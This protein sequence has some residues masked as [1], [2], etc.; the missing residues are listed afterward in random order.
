MIRVNRESLWQV[1][2]KYNMDG[3]L[4]NGIKSIYVNLLACVRV[5]WSESECFRV[6]S[7]MRQGCIISLWLFNVYINE[8]MKE[9]KM[10]M[11]KMG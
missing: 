2:R 1:T 5:K 4:L 8:V 6:D 3:K 10:G 7:G 9:M 11:G